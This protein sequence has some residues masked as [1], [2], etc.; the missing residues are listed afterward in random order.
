MKALITGATG[1]IGS[2]LVDELFKRGY[3]VTCLVRKTSDITWLEGLDIEIIEGDCSV[4]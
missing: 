1:F 3:K 2:H 4:Q